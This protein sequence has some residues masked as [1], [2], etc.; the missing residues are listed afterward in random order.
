MVSLINFRSVGDLAELQISQTS[1]TADE[2]EILRAEQPHTKNYQTTT[3]SS[4]AFENN[5]FNE[6][7]LTGVSNNNNNN[8]IKAP[9]EHLGDFYDKLP[10][11]SPS[12][13][14]SMGSHFEIRWNNLTYEVE[15][16][17]YQQKLWSRSDSTQAQSS[18]SGRLHSSGPIRKTKILN[19]LNG[20]VKSGQVTAILGPSGA[21]KTSLL[22]CLTGKNK[23]GVSGSIQVISNRHKPMS[24]C[25]I[26]QKGK[27]T[28]FIFIFAQSDIIYYLLTNPIRINTQITCSIS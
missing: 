7:D 5:A 24:I 15:P 16:K 26:P 19:N 2:S 23:S 13:P 17:W 3:A 28:S 27:S 22:G 20:S 4:N 11:K 9:L 12:S 10:A 14:S 8:E 6:V 18:S 21:G 1:P 25:T